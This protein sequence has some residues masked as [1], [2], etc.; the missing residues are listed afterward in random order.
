MA[1]AAGAAAQAIAGGLQAGAGILGGM[2][3][4][5]HA[6]KMYDKQRADNL[7]DWNMQNAYN[8]DMYNLQN[9]DYQRLWHQQNEYNY[10]MLQEQRQYDSP[11]EQ[12]K[13]F[14]A[15]G[16]NPHAMYGNMSGGPSIDAA[17]L[18][19]ASLPS[20]LLKGA[21]MQAW[22]APNIDF[23]QSIMGVQHMKAQTDNLKAQN[24][25]LQIDSILK[26]LD[27]TG[28]QLGNDKSK[29]ELSKLQDIYSGQIE[30]LEENIRNLRANTASTIDSNRRANEMQ[31]LQVEQIRESIS[32]LVKDGKLKLG[33]QELQTLESALKKFEVNL[34]TLGVTKNDDILTR[35][36]STLFQKLSK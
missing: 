21:N 24:H 12:M 23:I 1:A 11:E 18:Q 10:K 20:S 25:N 28:K 29:F 30:T 15:A 34:S 7:S 2:L 26:S 6:L 35:L 31:P 5:R 8:L 4:R 36:L 3:T 27:V 9:Q 19:N 16:I 17:T 13:R 33:Q 32:N 22:Q 14:R